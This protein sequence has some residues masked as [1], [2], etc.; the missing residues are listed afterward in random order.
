MP[1]RNYQATVLSYGGLKMNHV[2]SS[3][4]AQVT[5]NQMS[6]L[7]RIDAEN[8]TL[9]AKKAAEGLGKTGVVV[10]KEYLERA[11]FAL[12]QYYAVAM[13]DPA[14]A[15]AVTFSI[16]PFWHAHILFTEQ[17]RKFCDDVVGE[18]MDHVPLDHDD[19]EKVQNV[20][21][22]YDYTLDVL[23]KLF[24]DIDPIFWPQEVHRAD[25]I[26]YHKGNE[27]IYTCLQ[28][29]RLFEPTFSGSAWAYV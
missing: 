12:K 21:D 26:C 13:L 20:R 23:P 28:S 8:Y 24:Q 10:T 5:A 3:I 27:D 18:Y 1:S 17:Y 9:V 22:L 7:R 15:H 19:S 14:N 25:L 2:S 16:D 4:I 29:D 6:R 11:I